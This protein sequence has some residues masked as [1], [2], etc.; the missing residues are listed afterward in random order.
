MN[1]SV[2]ERRRFP[3]IND[4]KISLKV[5]CDHF[6]S[7]LSQSLNISASGVYCKVDKKIPLL[8][9]LKI[10]LMLTVDGKGGRSKV[11]KIETEGVV[12]REHPVIENGNVVHFD[13]AIFFDNLSL[14]DREMIKEYVLARSL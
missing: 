3:R 12:V 14:R 4:N 11:T 8:S 7:V 6:D 2:Q 9:R 5:K 10:I 1:E 13:V